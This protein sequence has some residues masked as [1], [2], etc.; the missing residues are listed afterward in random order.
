MKCSYLKWK[1]AEV[2]TVSKQPYLPSLFELEEYCRTAK[3][4]RCPFL[5]RIA[6]AAPR[7]AVEGE[8][9]PA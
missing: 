1:K 4:A 8:H 2:C 6:W 9:V 3:S 7:R 5:N